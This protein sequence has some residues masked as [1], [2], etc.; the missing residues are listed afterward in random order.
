MNL[1]TARSMHHAERDTESVSIV[2]PTYQRGEVL[3]QTLAMLFEQ[4][5]PADEILVVDQ[6]R[7]PAPE[8]ASRLASWHNQGQIRWRRLPQ[9]SIPHAMNVGLSEATG[10]I[11]L[12]L[13][14]DIVPAANLI[15]AHAGSLAED[16]QIWAVAGQVLQP[17][18]EPCDIDVPIQRNGFRATLEF[19]FYSTR[20]MDIANAM[21]GNLSVRRQRAIEIGGF[22]ENFVAIGFRFETEFAR[23]LIVRGGRVRFAPEASIR[24]L[25][26]E[27]GGTRARGS[28]FTSPDPG[29]G[30]GDYYFAMLQ[31]R[32]WETHRYMMWRLFRQITTRFHRRHPWY[33]P[34]K[35][36]GE[37]RAFLWARRLV[38]Q[39]PRLISREDEKKECCLPEQPEGY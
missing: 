26:A 10:T 3:L 35:L 2:I 38:Q 1:A 21:A 24:H 32:T 15:G 16:P 30:V 29:Y 7:T 27:R 33:I 14:D 12:F 28:Q 36:I 18:E 37:I 20:P 13:D 34:V 4:D 11:V 8:V 39:G 31:G 5:P 19:P 25:R 23:R 9:P 6:T 17:G 22:D